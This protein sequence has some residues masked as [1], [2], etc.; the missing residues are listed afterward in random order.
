MDNLGFSE[1]FRLGYIVVNDVFLVEKRNLV[2]GY[3]NV[4]IGL[5][6]VCS[7]MPCILQLPVRQSV[8]FG[9]IFAHMILLPSAG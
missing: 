5:A 2:M 3:I 9:D 8:K 4:K 1:A 7:S 6:A